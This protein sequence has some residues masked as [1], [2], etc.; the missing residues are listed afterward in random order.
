[1]RKKI[2][3]FRAKFWRDPTFGPPGQATKDLSGQ[4]HIYF[5]SFNHSASNGT[6]FNLKFRLEICLIFFFFKFQR[7]GPT[8]L[9]PDSTIICN[10]LIHLTLITLNNV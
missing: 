3:D 8:R 6:I 5:E 4:K 2:V 1:M 10:S 9:F 7:S